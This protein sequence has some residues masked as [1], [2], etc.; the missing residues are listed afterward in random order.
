M[1]VVHCDSAWTSLNSAKDDEFDK[2]NIM[3]SQIDLNLLVDAEFVSQTHVQ[4][5]CF[6]AH[7]LF[8]VYDTPPASVLNDN[9]RT[10][11]QFFTPSIILQAF[12]D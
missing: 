7:P 4:G 6:N 8:G 9:R 2:R 3:L 12:Y 10:E 5:R 1:R 11:A